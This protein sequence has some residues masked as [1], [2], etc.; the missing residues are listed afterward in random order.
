[1][2]GTLGMIGSVVGIG[3]GLNSLFGGGSS[4]SPGSSG[5]AGQPQFYQPTGQSSADNTWQ[6]MLQQMVGSAGGV[7][8]QV[9]PNLQEAYRMLSGISPVGYNQAAGQAGA[10][11]GDAASL[12]KMLQGQSMT[13]AGTASQAQQDLMGAG[14]SAYN[15]GLDPQKDLYNQ[16]YQQMLEQTNAA[17]SMRGIGMSPEAAGIQNQASEQ[18]NTG[19][20]NQQLQRQLA[21]LSGMQGAY[22][23]AG[24]QGTLAGANQSAA[25]GYGAAAPGYTLQSGQVPYQALQQAFQQPIQNANMYAGAMQQDVTSPYGAIQSNILPYLNYGQGAS[26]GAFGANL[27][28]SNQ[29]NQNSANGMNSLLTG[30]AGNSG[31]Q[32]NPW[33]MNTN[34]WSSLANMFSPTS[35][36]S[37]GLNYQ[38]GA[39]G[40]G[41]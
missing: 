14:K 38:A 2:A 23:G 31:Q 18:F 30:L 33:G 9:Q 19:W 11:Y 3:S 28:S 41:W 1:M 25:M 4:S 40:S 20:Q 7:A 36:T 32:A 15:A 24:Q 35:G 22:Q 34:A 37:T 8:G 5:P 17:T 10:G 21:G 29:A 6:Q 12:A 13:Q 26:S 27:Q 16:Q 39:N